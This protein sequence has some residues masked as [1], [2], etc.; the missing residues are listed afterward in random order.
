MKR[1]TLCF[2]L[3]NGQV[4]V[5]YKKRGFGAGKFAG[6]G[7]KIEPGETL[8]QAAVRELAEECRLQVDP[9]H[10]E[11]VAALT[12]IFPA[13]PSWNERVYAFLVRRWQ[14]QPLETEE[15]RPSW[16]PF[17]NIPYQQ[18]WQDNRLWLPRVLA[19]ECLRGRFVFR[20]DNE[21]V[22]N[23]T[24]QTQRTKRAIAFG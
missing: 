3:Y 2:P 8:A 19:G 15:M 16:F 11:Y 12:F 5:G 10:L 17:A 14:G 22:D 23:Y 18:M 21:T 1:L 9:F 13:R 4:L 24:I 20:E 7:G 6:F